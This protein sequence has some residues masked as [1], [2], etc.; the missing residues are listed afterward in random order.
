MIDSRDALFDLLPA[1]LRQRDLLGGS[2]LQQLLRVI[3]DQAI[4][5]ENDLARMYEDCFIETCAPWVIPFIGD[6]LGA[7]PAEGG[8]GGVGGERRAVGHLLASR[9]Q[10]GMF[11]AL[12]GIA[13]DI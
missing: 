9:R 8:T 6:L 7:S 11:G 4:A 2:V 1:Y 5:I 10:R 3:G 13:R 12:A